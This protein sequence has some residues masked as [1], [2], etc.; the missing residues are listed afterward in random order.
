LEIKVTKTYFNNK[1]YEGLDK[2][3]RYKLKEKLCKKVVRLTQIK[4]LMTKKFIIENH[5]NKGWVCKRKFIDQ[6][7]QI[8]A[9]GIESL[10]KSIL[11]KMIK[12]KRYENIEGKIKDDYVICDLMNKVS[13]YDMYIQKLQGTIEL[14]NLPTISVK[15]TMKY[16]ICYYTYKAIYNLKNPQ[17]R[18]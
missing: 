8:Y 18:A 14:I 11:Q 2:E 16:E 9:M 15:K 1:K 13:P 7:N 5:I 6:L 10:K 12:E 4:G 17:K 3:L